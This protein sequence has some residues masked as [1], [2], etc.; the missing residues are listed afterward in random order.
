MKFLL[1]EFT[2][3]HFR[4]SLKDASM[5][6]CIAIDNLDEITISVKYTPNLGS[7]NHFEIIFVNLGMKNGINNIKTDL[8][9]D[10]HSST[11]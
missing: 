10:S 8:S 1:H 4:F 5:I 11:A 9:I 6:N 3:S 2:I 7:G